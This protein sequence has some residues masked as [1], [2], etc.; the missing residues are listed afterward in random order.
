MGTRQQNLSNHCRTLR[1][2]NPYFLFL[3]LTLPKIVFTHCASFPCSGRKP[4][5][6]HTD[7]QARSLS[8]PS[9]FA[10]KTHFLEATAQPM[11]KIGRF[12]HWQF[13]HFL[14]RRDPFTANVPLI[15]FSTLSG[16]FPTLQASMTKWRV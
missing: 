7:G 12:P 4:Q 11:A 9:C 16:P 1:G 6:L 15:A 3:L 14:G 13:P 8:L 5:L 10:L 2:F